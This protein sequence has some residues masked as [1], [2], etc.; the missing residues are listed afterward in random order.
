MTT[1]FLSY[2]RGVDEP[3]VAR[4]YTDPGTHGFD[5]WRGRISMRSRGLTFLHEVRDAMDARE[6]FLLML[7]PKAI[8]STAGP[9]WRPP[10]SR[11][12]R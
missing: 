8:T 12:A 5:V 4:L 10:R 7:G 6:R 1:I 2:A 11:T 3:L 9:A